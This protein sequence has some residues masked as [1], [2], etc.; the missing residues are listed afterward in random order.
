MN[1]IGMNELLSQLRTLS[2][3]AQ[4]RALTAEP[5]QAANSFQSMLKNSIEGVNASQQTAET[6][7]QAFEAGDPN[8]DLASVMVAMQK[9]SL[10]FQ[11][12]VQVRNKLVSA[13]QEVMSMQV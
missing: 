8:T 5:V 9:A 4:G 6:M 2:T 10:S 3:Q 1:E 7:A 13:Y 11:A 12:M